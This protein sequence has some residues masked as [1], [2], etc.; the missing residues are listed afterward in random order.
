M[1]EQE[2]KTDIILTFCK[3]CNTSKPEND[4]YFYRP[5]KCRSCC[6]ASTANRIVNKE[7]KK[8]NNKKYYLK[9]K[10]KIIEHNTKYYHEKKAQYLA[11]RQLITPTL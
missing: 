4:F 11:K 9:H 6:T 7:T 8:E 3:Y 2:N 5:K 10:T 1:T